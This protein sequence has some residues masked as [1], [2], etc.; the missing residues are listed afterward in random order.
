MNEV[1]KVR[2]TES[3]PDTGDWPLGRTAHAGDAAAALHQTLG[4]P[5]Q[6]SLRETHDD[7]ALLLFDQQYGDP[8]YAPAIYLQQRRL[9]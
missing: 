4:G 8:V 1:N 5:A 2:D 3:A 9:P 7:V 6:G